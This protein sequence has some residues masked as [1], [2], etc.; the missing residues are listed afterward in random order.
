MII[1]IIRISIAFVILLL[2]AQVAP[3]ANGARA[4]DASSAALDPENTLY[5]DLDYGRVVIRM[6]PDLAP[7]HVERIKHLTRGG[8]FDG[9]IFHRVLAGFM[10]Q[11][12][13]PKGTGSGGSGR[14]LKAE[15]TKT[16][17][18][19]GIVSMA[20]GSGKNSG[21]SQWFIVLA[22][23]RQAL[24]GKYTVWGEVTSGMDFVDMI[25]KG[26]ERRNGKVTNPD[27]MLRL[28]VAADA[29]RAEKV[30][31]ADLLNAPDAAA[32][33][34]N[35]TGEEFRC[36]ALATG[37]T[38]QPALAQLWAHG[39]VAGVYKARNALTFAGT[40]DEAF[41]SALRDVCMQYPQA[42]LLAAASQELAK[43]PRPM[44]PATAAFS[45]VSYACKDYVAARNGANKAE[46]DFADL[47]GFAFIQ[48]YKSVN[49]PGLEMPFE[50]RPQLL[51]AVAGACAKTPEVGFLDLTALV[52]EKVKLK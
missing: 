52:A 21:D 11:T 16:P 25:H 19:R 29:D 27:R 35:F 44:S 36:A 20:L 46:A 6:R 45:P 28:Q 50:V 4:A 26:D 39:Y 49:Q 34:R 42:F 47:W 30:A 41:D 40:A 18:V 10:A 22:D 38:A 43:V 37:V 13:D 51:G 15:F 2:L 1:M 32:T 7:N 17:Q 24:D 48:G 33:A 9:L 14:T 12:G 23:S 3:A 31:S 5:L 8:F